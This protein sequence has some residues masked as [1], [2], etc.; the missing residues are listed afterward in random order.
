[1]IREFSLFR[2]LLAMMLAVIP[3]EKTISFSLSNQKNTH[4]VYIPHCEGEVI[5]LRSGRYGIPETTLTANITPG[6]TSKCALKTKKGQYLT[7]R[8]DDGWMMANVATIGEKELFEVTFLEPDLITLKASNGRYVTC[9][10]G[11]E[12]GNPFVD[13]LK[14]IDNTIFRLWM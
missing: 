7:Y 3:Q 10:Y 11:P 1:M 6:V 12:K 4:Y 13:S 8:D 2:S 9:V 5:E 14:V